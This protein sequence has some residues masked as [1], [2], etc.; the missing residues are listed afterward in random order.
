MT[1]LATERTFTTTDATVTTA[2]IY[3][4]VDNSA[5]SL[6]S[7]ISAMQSDGSNRKVFEVN[8]YVFRDGAG[9]TIQGVAFDSF[10]PFGTA[11][12]AAVVVTFDVSGNDVRLRVT[13]IAAT[14]INWRTYTEP[15]ETT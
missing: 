3:T 15:V 8:V 7:R 1:A 10:V 4:L 11:G 12:F 9:A 14:T 6:K 13:G 5:I 2:F